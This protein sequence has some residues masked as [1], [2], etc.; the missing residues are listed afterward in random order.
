M[1]VAGSSPADGFAWNLDM[2]RFFFYAYTNNLPMF[3]NFGTKLGGDFIP[4][5][6]QKSVGQILYGFVAEHGNTYL[7][8]DI[9]I[10]M[11]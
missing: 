3:E 1:G 6:D 5:K 10:F 8:R 9:T 11:F 2:S 4:R 7:W